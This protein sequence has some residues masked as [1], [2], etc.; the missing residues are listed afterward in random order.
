MAT[1]LLIRF[2]LVRVGRNLQSL[3]FVIYDVQ[4]KKVTI[5]YLKIKM[6]RNYFA[7][8]FIALSIFFILLFFTTLLMYFTKEM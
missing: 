5:G 4:S 3:N 6:Y 7:V 8:V 1:N 2:A